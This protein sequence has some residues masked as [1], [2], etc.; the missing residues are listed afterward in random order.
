MRNLKIKF[1]YQETPSV[2]LHWIGR[3]PI[4][5]GKDV[6]SMYQISP[7]SKIQ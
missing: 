2:S 4:K 6:L 3:V 1:S 5:V 7:E